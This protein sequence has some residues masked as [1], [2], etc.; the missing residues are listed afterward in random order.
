MQGLT[1]Y[2]QHQAMSQEQERQ[3]K[4]AEEATAQAAAERKKELEENQASTLAAVTGI[5]KESEEKTIQ[6]L[7]QLAAR[8]VTTSPTEVAHDYGGD[9]SD[10]YS[11]SGGRKRLNDIL[12]VPIATRQAKAKVAPKVKAKPKAQPRPLEA[13]LIAIAKYGL[14]KTFAN[15]ILTDLEYDGVDLDGLADWKLITLVNALT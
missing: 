10:T 7:Q 12:N 1:G 13:Q 5:L 4:L 9:A 8:V 3:R 6:R 11:I 14:D 2:L 15:K